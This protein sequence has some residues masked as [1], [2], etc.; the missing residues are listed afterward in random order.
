MSGRGIRARLRDG[1]LALDI[2]AAMARHVTGAAAGVVTVAVVARSLG[3]AGLGAWTLLGTSSYLLGLADLGLATVVQRRLVASEEAER[4]RAAPTF[5]L[6]LGVVALAAPVL[7]AITAALVLATVPRSGAM[8]CATAIALAGGVLGAFTFPVRAAL[9]VRGGVREVSLARAAGAALQVA[10]TVA[11]TTW[12]RSLV[13]PALGLA[14][15][16]LLETVLLGRALWARAP[17][18]VARPRLSRV[19]AE[20]RPA[21]GEAS[22]AL[23]I[24][25]AV[26]VVARLDVFVLAQVCPLSLVAAYGLATRACDQA[27]LL[28]KQTSSALLGRLGRAEGREASVRAGAAVLHAVAGGGLASL[29]AFGVPLLAAWG[30][31]GARPSAHV[32]AL[33]A[34][35][36][37][38]GSWSEIPSVT[39][40]LG[41]TTPWRAAGPIVLGSAVNGAL[42]VAV[43]PLRSATGIAMASVIGCAVTATLAWRGLARMLA[44]RRRDV[45]LALLPGAV[46]SV[47]A[48]AF[49]SALAA[50][51]TD[52]A[53]AVAA[54]AGGSALALASGLAVSRRGGRAG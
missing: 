20:L 36:G 52:A 43:A 14:A 34:T 13:G 41:A 50:F 18:L 17:E 6:S 26:A 53:R 7:A 25:G 30:G 54:T 27:L 31:E 21:L 24:N 23:A 39:V 37:I 47:V 51:A 28:A 8:T 2:G 33:L 10:V 15:A 48:I 40:G 45:V 35:A 38:L 29:A 11:A 5:A 44:W 22:A 3:A 9:L 42:T 32:L 4:T 1:E 16:L 46:A 19:R 12:L 49:G